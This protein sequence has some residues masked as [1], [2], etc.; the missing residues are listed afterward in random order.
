MTRYP[1]EVKAIMLVYFN[2]SSLRRNESGITIN[3]Q[4]SPN[5]VSKLAFP[6]ICRKERERSHINAVTQK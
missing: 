6:H 1:I 2:E 4:R 3:L 5:Q